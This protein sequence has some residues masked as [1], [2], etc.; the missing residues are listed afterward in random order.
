M[1]LVLWTRGFLSKKNYLPLEFDRYIVQ[2]INLAPTG[3]STGDR[4]TGQHYPS[5][6]KIKF[7]L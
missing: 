1:I 7:D 4:Y 5:L 6:L 3:L 2:D